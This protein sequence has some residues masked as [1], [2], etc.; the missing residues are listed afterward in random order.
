MKAKHLVLALTG[1]L[2]ASPAFANESTTALSSNIKDLTSQI[3]QINQDLNAKQQKQQQ[4]NAALKDSQS[5]ITKSQALLAKLR[6]QRDGDLGQLQ[7]LSTTLPQMTSSVNQ[8]KNAVS[9]EIS[10]IYLQIKKV[11]NDQQSILSGNDSLTATRKKTYLVEI[12]NLEQARYTQLNQKLTE[13]QNLNNRLQ[14]EVNRLN[15][16][17]GEKSQQHEQLMAVKDTTLKQAIVVKQQ[18]NQEKQQ[19]SHLKQ[20]QAELNNLLQKLAMAERQQRLQQQAAA[21]KA[22][23][24]ANKNNSTTQPPSGTNG[25]NKPQVNDNTVAVGKTD[26]SV[27]DNSPFMARK[28][29]K[30][31][32]GNILVGFGQMRDSVKNNGVLVAAT[33]SPIYAISQG[34]VLFSGVLPGFGQIV[35][36]DNGDNYTSVYSGILSKVNKG[37]RVSS[38]QQIGLS[39]GA[40]NQPMGGVYF[41]L[42]H[43]GK[44]VNPSRLF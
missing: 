28:L 17:L 32:A 34:T 35:V 11:Q 3:T 1:L 36:I 29:T 43:L 18:I 24:Q 31:V 8:A 37:A 26:T 20:R 44:P 16:S 6:K 10:Q 22:M 21:R 30:P 38:G 27:E 14:A 2:I 9:Q 39:G 12:L 19:L 41:E 23:Q 4:I 40:D 25:T 7:Q 13:L 15:G 42:R 5:A 33:N